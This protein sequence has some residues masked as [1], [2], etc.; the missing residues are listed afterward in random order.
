[1]RPT[2]AWTV[3]LLEDAK[4]PLGTGD[5]RSYVGHTRKGEETMRRKFGVLCI[6]ATVGCGEGLEDLD[7][8]S[9]QP[10]ETVRA[11]IGEAG[12]LATPPDAVID[13]SRAIQ[14]VDSPVIYDHTSCRRAWMV[15]TAPSILP[16][17]PAAGTRAFITWQD[18]WP[19]NRQQC[20]NGSLTVQAM[21]APFSGHNF[22]DHGT[23][24]ET[25]RWNAAQGRCDY[26]VLEI[27]YLA[28]VNKTWIG[29]WQLMDPSGPFYTVLSTFKFPDTFNGRRLKLAVSGRT[30]GGTT[31]PVRIW[32]DRP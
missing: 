31:Q 20:V 18:P 15:E 19:R 30:P 5:R 23:Y 10:Y 25:M 6:L 17:E 4:R 1:M 14:S 3:N 2:A 22:R 12:C 11:A 21:S 13:V 9:G 7:S 32:W 29:Q 16:R 27:R 24:R 26:P 8:E 28:D